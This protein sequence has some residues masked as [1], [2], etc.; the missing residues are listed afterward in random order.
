MIRG[1]SA[2]DQ[3]KGLESCHSTG[4]ASKRQ[5]F[6]DC[7]QIVRIGVFFDGT[8]QN[9]DHPDEIK[10][11]SHSNIARLWSAHRRD[12]DQGIFRIYN[13]GPGTPVEL[14]H[15]RWWEYIPGSEKAGLAFGLGGDARL[16]QA[17][18]EFRTDLTFVPRIRHIELS[19]FGFS[20]GAAL[21]RGFVNRILGQCHKVGGEFLL[22]GKHPVVFKFLGIFD[23]VASFGLPAT[24]LD[25]GDVRLEIPDCVGRVRHFVAAHELRFSFPVDTIRA[26][27]RYPSG[28]RVERVYP[29]VHSDVGGGYGPQA[30]GRAFDL[31]KI[32]CNDMLIECW[33]AGL[34]FM[35]KQQIAEK[36]FLLDMFDYPESSYKLYGDYL[37]SVNAQGSVEAQL[38]LHSLAYYRYRGRSAQTPDQN[39]PAYQAMNAQAANARQQYS[40]VGRTGRRDRL[41]GATA[42]LAS[43]EGQ[44]SD[45]QD[46]DRDIAYEARKLGA[47]RERSEAGMFNRAMMAIG[48][49]GIGG[50]P[51]VTA[52]ELNTPLSQDEAHMLDAWQ[53]G[54]RGKLEPSVQR[55][56]EAFVHDSKAHFLPEPTGYFRRR[57]VYQSMYVPPEQRVQPAPVKKKRAA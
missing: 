8:G 14:S 21:A 13:S 43:A 27:G 1:A 44:V 18:K 23:T 12:P 26:K 31:A 39:E 22:D 36:A 17:E 49:A 30:Q 4:A 54:A 28:D 20:R 40:E 5:P 29:G 19:V 9:K 45:Y 57:G 2:F 16:E 51:S 33:H 32:I 47:R 25:S 15:P 52:A 56:F 7:S 3:I 34:P 42:Q 24:N 38:F 10:R 37:R 35:T 55:F 53:E 50:V 48:S 11:R 46:G 41:R 6:S